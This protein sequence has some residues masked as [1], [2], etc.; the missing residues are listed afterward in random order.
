MN[1][2]NFGRST[3]IANARSWLPAV[4]GSEPSRHSLKHR[5]ASL[6]QALRMILVVPCIYVE[7]FTHQNRYN[8]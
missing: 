1:A 3:E 5:R 2:A 7:H 6:S 8:L 4:A